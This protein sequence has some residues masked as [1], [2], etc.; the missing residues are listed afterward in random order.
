MTTDPTDA[1]LFRILI[2]PDDL[3]R[4]REP[5]RLMLDKLTTVPGRRSV[6][7]SVV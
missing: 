4:L 5:S 3:N 7:R 2:E 1:P 6:S